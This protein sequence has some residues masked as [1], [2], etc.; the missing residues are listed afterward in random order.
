MG[1][2]FPEFS[3]RFRDMMAALAP[4]TIAVVGHARPDGDCIG[5]QVALARVLRSLGRTVV[6]ANPDP[7][8]R[9]LKFLAAGLEFLPADALTGEIQAIFVDCADHSRAGEKMRRRFPKPV[10][11]VDHHLSNTGYADRNFVDTAAAATCE[12]LAGMFFDNDYPID[13]ATA[14]ALY[15]GIITDTGQFRFS[16]T[17]QQ[18]F[19]LAAGLVAR[20]ARPRRWERSC[21]SARRPASC[22]CCSG[23]S[24]P[25]RWSLRDGSAS[26]PWR[27]ESLPRPGPR[28]KTPKVSWTMPGAWMACRLES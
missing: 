25:L 22:G 9:R 12:I 4:G 5:A 17:T 2:Y 7:V 28:V 23:S 14:A 15:A 27:T 24:H 20:G 21:M 13:A 10:A 11:N 8:P 1:P 18:T 16:S 26:E 19:E 3:A 6:C